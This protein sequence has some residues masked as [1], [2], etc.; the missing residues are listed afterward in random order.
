MQEINYS[1]YIDYVKTQLQTMR[2]ELSS[3]RSNDVR[4]THMYTLNVV[5]SDACTYDVYM[6]RQRRVT[7]MIMICNQ[8]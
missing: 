7:V 8:H 5:S 4:Y 6:Q 1:E 3:K 2:K